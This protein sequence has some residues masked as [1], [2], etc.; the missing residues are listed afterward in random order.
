MGNPL[1]LIVGVW[2]V[3]WLVGVVLAGGINPWLDNLKK[4][5]FQKIMW[6]GFFISFISLLFYK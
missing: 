1:L 5:K 2:I 6:A 4:S 3:L